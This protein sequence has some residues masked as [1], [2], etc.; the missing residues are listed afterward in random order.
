[1]LHFC[2]YSNIPAINIGLIA[3]TGATHV[4]SHWSQRFLMI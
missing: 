1:M 4:T 2:K 3:I